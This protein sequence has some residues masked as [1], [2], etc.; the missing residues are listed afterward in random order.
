MSAS[1]PKTGQNAI[2]VGP[3]SKVTLM[4]CRVILLSDGQTGD[5]PCARAFLQLAF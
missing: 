3:Q 1:P 2:G 5:S 4:N